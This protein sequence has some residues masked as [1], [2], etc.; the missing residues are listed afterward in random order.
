MLRRV[1]P[2]LGLASPQGSFRNWRTLA[3]PS[4]RSSVQHPR[5]LRTWLP[6][7]C[8]PWPRAPP[9]AHPNSWASVPAGGRH[10]AVTRGTL[11]PNNPAG[12]LG[13]GWGR[14]ALGPGGGCPVPP[15]VPQTSPTAPG[16]RSV[17]SC[18]AHLAQ[19][20]D[21]LQGGPHQ[22]GLGLQQS[23]RILQPPHELQ[24][25]RPTLPAGV[26]QACGK[27]AVRASAREPGESTRMRPGPGFDAKACLQAPPFPWSTTSTP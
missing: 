27:R 25:L 21:A 12:S 11:T 24:R 13:R 22:A 26:D 7:P 19:L 5:W 16:P 23:L 9:D 20:Q 3:L 18:T 2:A 10:P 1:Q 14:R 4:P 8:P 17:P 15:H 6:S